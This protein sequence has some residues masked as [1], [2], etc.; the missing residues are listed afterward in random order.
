MFDL[1]KMKGG[2]IAAVVGVVERDFAHAAD[3]EL[4]ARLGLVLL[5]REVMATWTAE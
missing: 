4:R 5:H 3:R 2:A 1:S